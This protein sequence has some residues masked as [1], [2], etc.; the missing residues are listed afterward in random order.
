MDHS[1]HRYLSKIPESKALPLLS[2]LPIA[3]ST[4]RVDAS[5]HGLPE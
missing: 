4:A 2:K 3:N 1:G 5:K